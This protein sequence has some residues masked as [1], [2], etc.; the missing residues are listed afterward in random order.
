VLA[1]GR[2]GGFALLYPVLRAMEEAGR[3]R[4]GY[5]VE[6]MG[7]SQF[8]LPGAVDRLRTLREGDDTVICLAATDPAQPYGAVLPWPEGGR[9]ARQAGAFVVLDGGRL[10]CYLE[11][12][13]R[14]LLTAGELRAEHLRALAAAALRAGKL[15]IQQ[16]DARPVYDTPLAGALRE[17]GFGASPRGM[18]LYPKVAGASA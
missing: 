13:G 10:A 12:G 9:M 3:V 17:A 5:F 18:V 1:E 11:R 4:R 14:S 7:G 15:E 6:G 16:V 2:P 8:A